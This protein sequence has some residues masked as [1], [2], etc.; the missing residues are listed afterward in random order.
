MLGL[1][2]DHVTDHKKRINY[3][4]GDFEHVNKNSLPDSGA[5]MFVCRCG[6]AIAAQKAF[7]LLETR[8]QSH[9]YR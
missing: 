5:S 2:F 1:I 3:F 7:A 8:T 4:E 6:T 9:T